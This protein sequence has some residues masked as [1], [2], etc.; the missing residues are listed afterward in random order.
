M[1]DEPEYFYHAELLFLFQA[2]S[3]HKSLA[4]EHDHVGDNLHADTQSENGA[5]DNQYN[6]LKGVAVGI[7]PGQQY[8]REIDKHAEKH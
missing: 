8:H 7:Y 3:L 5:T 4:R 2:D 6:E 1:S